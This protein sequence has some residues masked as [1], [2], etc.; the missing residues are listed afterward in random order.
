MWVFVVFQ[1]IPNSVEALQF[2]FKCV[3]YDLRLYLVEKMFDNW[4]YKNMFFCYRNH[5]T[6]MEKPCVTF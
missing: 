1:N 5:I 6:I 3:T 4:V 2:H